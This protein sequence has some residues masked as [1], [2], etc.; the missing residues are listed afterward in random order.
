VSGDQESVREMES[1]IAAH[2]SAL[3][4]YAG[5]LLRD[6]HAAQD[7]VQNAFIKLFRQWGPGMKPTPMLKAWLFRVVHNEAVDHMRREK[8]R[9]LLHERH[10]MENKTKPIRENDQAEQIECILAA[11]RRLDADEQQVVLLRIQEGLSYREISQITGRSEGNVGCI[12]HHAV[13]K[14]GQWVKRGVDGAKPAGILA[15]GGQS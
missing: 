10:A 5:G 4:R 2:E 3:L 11:V 7:V 8:R 15:G 6:A 13:K 14:V 1:V 9:G 12:L